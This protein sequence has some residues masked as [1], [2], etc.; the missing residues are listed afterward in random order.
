M[1]WLTVNGPQ[2]FHT[3]T[4]SPRFEMTRPNLF[5]YATKELSQDAVLAWLIAWADPKNA[6]FS[7]GLH[8][9]GA[10]ILHEFFRLNKKVMP[11]IN[12]LT[13][14][15][16][17]KNIDLVVR[18]ND[19][20]TI[21]IED[22]VGSTEH[23]DQLVRYPNA[24]SSEGVPVEKCLLVYVQTHEQSSYKAVEE[25][26]YFRF[27]RADFLRLFKESSPD[28]LT[29]S[30]ARDFRN[31][32]LQLEDDF[33][34]WKLPFPDWEKARTWQGFYSEL[35]RKTIG[36]DWGPVSNPRGGFQ[37]FWWGIANSE[38]V[39][40]L[41]LEEGKLCFKLT[42]SNDQSPDLA[43]QLQQKLIKI[44]GHNELD[45]CK[46]TIRGATMTVAQFN[47]DYRMLCDGR[48]DLDATVERLR[49]AEKV[50]SQAWAALS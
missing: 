46:T 9:L 1:F 49:L 34:S 44:G 36:G 33:N 17:H 42:K 18:I 13:I 3:S 39:P 23:N 2:A 38:G 25:A 8:A 5:H 48:L 27:T 4:L 45:V 12:S 21:C 32:L 41:Q 7:A 37:G 40:Y 20:W 10:S 19:E 43:H 47:G 31:W 6:Q 16:Q 35:Q 28:V 50:L 30:I 14:K 11:V 22:K 29:D 15:R 24:I 26:G